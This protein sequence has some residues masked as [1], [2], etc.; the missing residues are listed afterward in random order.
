L[1][2]IDPTR[3][4]DGGRRFGPRYV[5]AGLAF[6]A[7]ATA[8]LIDIWSDQLTF[9]DES[10]PGASF[11]PVVLAVLLA[12]LGVAFALTR[13]KRIEAGSDAEEEPVGRPQTVKFVVLVAALILLFPY[14]GGLLSLSLFVVVEMCWVER[15]RL[16]LSLVMGVAAFVAVWL[17]FVKLLSV[18]L[19]LGILPGLFG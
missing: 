17:I 14:L 2:A 4:P 9:W 10:G 16:W 8:A 3:G 6:V 13:P 11:F 1:S 18:P 19:P 15:S 5:I 12:V 7:V